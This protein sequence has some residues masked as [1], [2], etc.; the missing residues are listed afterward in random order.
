MIKYI[1]DAGPLITACKFQVQGLYI[2]DHLLRHC[3]VFV[4]ESVK[5][6]VVVAGTKYDDAKVAKKRIDSGQ[7]SV[8]YPPNKPELASLITP[9]KLGSGE[10]D[11][12]LLLGHPS[13]QKATLVI[14]DHL[15]YLVCSRLGKPRL[16]LLDAIIELV[17]NNLDRALALHMIDAIKSR[18]PAAFIEHTRLMLQR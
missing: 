1:F 13:L 7:I 14:D 3:D 6:E 8:L 5:N 2:I 15:A 12:I 9:Y 11:S 16:F 10:M 18:Y 4:A 17:E